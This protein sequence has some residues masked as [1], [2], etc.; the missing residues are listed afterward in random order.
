MQ[1]LL[2]HMMRNS[3]MQRGITAP[4]SAHCTRTRVTLAVA[5]F[6]RARK[7]PV[8]SINLGPAAIHFLRDSL[9]P[10]CLLLGRSVVY[11]QHFLLLSVK[12]KDGTTT[13]LNQTE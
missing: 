1:H 8:V 12:R 4:T 10:L 7:C 9:C 11:K 2:H 3:V 5:S 13:E 6:K